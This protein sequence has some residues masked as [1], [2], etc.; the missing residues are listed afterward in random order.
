[1]SERDEL[2]ALRRLAELEAKSGSAPKAQRPLPANAGLANFAA[3]VAGIPVN[4]VENALN[5][6]RAAQ[7]AV[8]GAM[9]KTEWMPPLLSG[10]VGGSEWIKEQLRKTGEPGLSPDDPSQTKMGKAQFDL[11]SRGGFVPGGFLPAAGSMVAEKVGGPEWAGV[12]AM[13]PQA[14]MTAYNAARAPSLA[15]QESQNAVRDKTFREGREEGYVVPPSAAGGGMVSNTLESFG[16]K[17]AMGQKAAIK[18]Q[19]VTNAIARREAGLPENAAISVDALKARREVLA[20]PYR[21][22]RK[23][24]PNVSST[25]DDLQDTRAESTGYWQEY[26]RQG[27][28]ASLREARKLDTKAATLEGQLE[29]AAISAGNPDLVRELRSARVAI[30][31]THDVE[32]ALNLGTGDVS[33]PILGQMY[34]KGKPFTGGMA[35]AGR[36]QQAF[37]HFMRE[38]EKVPSPDVSATNLMASGMLGYGGFQTMGLPGLAMAAIPFARGGARAGLLSGPAQNALIP[39]YAP[40]QTTPDV[41]LLMQLGLLPPPK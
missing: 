15:R 31:K 18:N 4:A 36:F 39:N 25:L 38:G 37:P 1:V 7:G 34:D 28:M 12:G 8:A 41:Q 9:G 33:A 3:S 32:R 35:T 30:A 6:G 29:Q 26:A 17:A 22:L 23:I 13:T 2:M 10:S 19:Q 16:G 40:V 27:T 21:E 5:L 20:A 11:M 24:S 14:A